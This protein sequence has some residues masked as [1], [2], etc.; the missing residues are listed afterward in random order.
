[1]AGLT[2]RG[3]WLDDAALS[4]WSGVCH[5]VLCWPDWGF[6]LGPHNLDP[7]ARE[8]EG[9]TWP[10]SLPTTMVNGGEALGGGCRRWSCGPG[11]L[12]SFW[13]GAGGDGKL[14]RVLN[15]DGGVL[16]WSRSSN[17]V[18][19]AA[20]CLVGGGSGA[21]GQEGGRYESQM[22]RPRQGKRGREKMEEGVT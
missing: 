14:A 7:T 15:I 21:T 13:Q 11:T 16:V 20:V 3:I 12:G 9:V 10:K 4:Y 6:D 19:H 17:G 18:W 2:R 5:G 8:G 22:K 1:L